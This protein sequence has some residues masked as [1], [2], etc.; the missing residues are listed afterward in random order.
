MHRHLLYGME[1]EE[2]QTGTAGLLTVFPKTV[3]YV[4]FPRM[5]EEHSFL[6][7]KFLYL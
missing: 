7:M 3:I 5:D 4:S 1:N 2:A 6:G